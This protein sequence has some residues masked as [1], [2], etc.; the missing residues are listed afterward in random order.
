M[1][2]RVELLSEI[3]LRPSEIAD[4]IGKSTPYVSA[5]LISIKRRSSRRKKK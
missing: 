3:G 1:S 2:D 5:T 4:I